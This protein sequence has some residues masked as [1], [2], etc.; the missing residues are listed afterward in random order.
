MA[1]KKP[2][3]GP[4]RRQSKRSPEILAADRLG[5]SEHIR[6]IGAAAGLAI[7]SGWLIASAFLGLG[8]VAVF[9]PAGVIGAAAIASL[10]SLG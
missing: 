10:L 8:D 9:A 5:R 6:R 7:A 4:E 1:W 3:T 2:Y